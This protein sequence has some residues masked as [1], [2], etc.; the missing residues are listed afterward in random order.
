MRVELGPQRGDQGAVLRVDRADAVEAL[1]VAGNLLEPLARD[2]APARDVL[3]ERHHVVH[4]LGPAERDD[5]ERVEER[6]RVTALEAVGRGLSVVGIAAILAPSVATP[7]VKLAAQTDTGRAEMSDE[8]YD[9]GLE[10]RRDVLGAEYVERAMQNADEFSADFQRFVTEYCWGACWGRDALPR[11]TRSLLVLAIL[12]TAG[13]L[14][15]IRAPLPRRAPERLH[16]RGAAGRALP[17][18]RLRR[19]LPAR[20]LGF[21]IGTPGARRRAAPS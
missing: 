20:C 19:G 10:I 6:G 21:R 16:A 2:V 18:R 5:E 7:C 12:A 9:K 8:V 11:T 13:R 14:G 15:R 4:A 17:R 3:E 1:V